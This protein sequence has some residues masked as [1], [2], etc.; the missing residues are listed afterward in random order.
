MRSILIAAAGVASLAV[1]SANAAEQL[2]PDQARAFVAGRAFSFNCF[3]GT[4]GAG[5][6]YPDGSVAGTITLREK[7]MRF[8]R[9]PPDTLRVRSGAICGYLKGLGFEPCFDVVKTGPA[10]FRGTL[11]GVQTMWCDFVSSDRTRVASPRK[12][13][14]T[15]T[16]QA[17]T[18]AE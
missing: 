13:R 11:S 14:T 12:S 6:I 2:N 17:S 16:A 1:G 15:N 5:R 9:L 7:P 8:V 4:K 18:T 10:S 3:E